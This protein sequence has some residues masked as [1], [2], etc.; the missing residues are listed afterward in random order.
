MNEEYNEKSMYSVA[1]KTTSVRIQKGV[2]PEVAALLD[3]SDLSRFGSDVEDMEEDF[4]VQANLPEEEEKL[5]ISNSMDSAEKSMINRNGAQILHASAS[6]KVV[7]DLGPLEGVPNGVA[8]VDCVNEKPRIR[9]LLDE[10]FDLV[11]SAIINAFYFLSPCS[12]LPIV[13]LLEYSYLDIKDF[14]SSFTYLF[15]VAR[16]NGPLL[17]ACALLCCMIYILIILCTL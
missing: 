1:S 3:D 7:D 12:K 9:R 14:F 4:V 16:T 8:G 17:I 11:S 6:S 5:H 2:D 13:L 10:Q 15:W